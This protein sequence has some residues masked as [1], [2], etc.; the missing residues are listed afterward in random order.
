MTRDFLQSKEWLDFQK[1]FGRKVFSFGQEG[2]EQ[3][4]I[5]QELPL[6]GKYLY[7]PRMNMAKDDVKSLLELA[8]KEKASWVRVDVASRK[9]MDI[10][11]GS[12]KNPLVKAPHDMQPR[13]VFIVGLDKSEEELLLGMKAKTRYNIRLAEKKGVVVRKAASDRKKEIEEFLRL[14]KTMA[15]RQGITPHEDGYYRKMFE[16]IPDDILKLYVAEFEGKIIAADAVA[17]YGGTATYLHGASD[18]ELRNVMAPYLLKWEEILEAKRRGCESFDFGGV[19]TA[20]CLCGEGNCCTSD[21]KKLFGKK[22]NTWEGITRFKLGFSISEEP[23]EFLGS[24]DMIL[25]PV[26]Y[27]AYRLLQRIKNF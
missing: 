1:S 23:T 20:D 5:S 8:E 18:D 26:R 12:G 9:D 24:W 25:D 2:S 10:L 7:V 13:E 4:A 21:L 27:W 14:T 11:K 16:S 22:E 6:V 3:G 15:L 17:F 19:K